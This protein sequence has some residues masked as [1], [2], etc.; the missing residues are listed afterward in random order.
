MKALEKIKLSREAL[1]LVEQLNA[2]QLKALAKIKAAK[3]VVEI[4]A[5]LGAAAKP[6]IEPSNVNP[7][8]QSVI[9]GAAP[10]I[11]LLKSLQA[12]AEKDLEHPQLRPAV[13]IIYDKVIAL[14]QEQQAA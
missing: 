1:G 4:T 5:A 12:E 3:R 11:E 9:D 10:S 2:G 6:M 14:T 13:E 8:Y 7:L